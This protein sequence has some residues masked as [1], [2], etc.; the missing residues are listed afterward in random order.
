MRQALK[1]FDAQE[2][3]SDRDRSITLD[4][5]IQACVKTGRWDDALAHCTESRQAQRRWLAQVLPAM[6]P[7]EQLVFLFQVERVPLLIS[8][9]IALHSA[10][11]PKTAEISAEWLLN[12]KSLSAVLGFI[13]LIGG[14]AG[15]IV[16]GTGWGFLHFS[17]IL[18]RLVR[19]D[20][21]R[22]S[23]E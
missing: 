11:R 5:L 23:S 13:V 16:A 6:A 8:L 9:A 12:S 22:F 2:V 1:S 18:D 17:Q 3:R 15:R 21:R 14:L 19:W 7:S 4:G 20:G 10:E